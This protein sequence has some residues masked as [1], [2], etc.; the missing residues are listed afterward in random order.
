MKISMIRPVF[1]LMT[2]SLLLGTMAQ[3]NDAPY[4]F[5]SVRDEKRYKALIEELRCP[6]CQNNNIADSNASVS[7]DLRR[8]VYEQIQ[9][10]RNNDEIKTYFSDRYGDFVL[11][12]PPVKSTTLIIWFGP[13]VALLLSAIVLL[14]V[15]RARQKRVIPPD[16]DQ[17]MLDDQLEQ[18]DKDLP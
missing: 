10:G 6:K 3:A 8:L 13:L 9:Q 1:L 11:Y 18:F 4:T 14:A 5:E 17:A 16:P 15:I 2:L 7:V 12:D